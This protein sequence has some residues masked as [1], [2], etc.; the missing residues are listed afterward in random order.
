MKKTDDTSVTKA[1]KQRESPHSAGESKMGRLLCNNAVKVNTDTRYKAATRPTCQ[2]ERNWHLWVGGPAQQCSKQ[3]CLWH[4]KR[5][6]KLPNQQEK[7]QMRAQSHNSAPCSLKSEESFPKGQ[8]WLSETVLSRK[9][10]ENY[11]PHGSIFT[12]P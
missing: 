2:Q 8:R 4:F 7:D 10:G 3:C 9:K 6:N 12:K 1:V 5:R 11:I